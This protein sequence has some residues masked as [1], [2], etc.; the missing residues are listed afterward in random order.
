LETVFTVFTEMRTSGVVPDL[1]AFNA[2][3]NAC[4]MVGD[5]PRAEEAFGGLCAAGL[6][7]DAISYGTLLKACAV[8]GD[9]ARAESIHAEM[10]Q[11][12]NHF[13]TFT[14]PTTRTYKHLL[15]AHA[16]HP[17]RVLELFEEMTARG[18]SPGQTH[19][20][21]ALRATAQHPG[22]GE[23]AVRRAEALYEGMRAAGFRLD[24]AT[25]LAL[26][27]LCAAWGR[28]D[29]S[30]RMRRERSI[31]PTVRQEAY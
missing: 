29:L 9:A 12:T 1:A 27:R 28:E 22:L 20:A 14:A 25:L 11:R 21:L 5:L 23:A 6:A 15:A 31:D 24:T 10:Q 4:A 3:M 7:P 2:L 8:A 13:S 17:P 26:D 19:Y 30:S 16:N 18:V